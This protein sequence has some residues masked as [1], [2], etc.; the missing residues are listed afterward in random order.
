MKTVN[1]PTI[2]G[3]VCASIV[4]NMINLSFAL[5]NERTGQTGRQLCW[6]GSYSHPGYKPVLDEC[7]NLEDAEVLHDNFLYKEW[8]EETF[9][10]GNYIYEGYKDISF[11]I[12]YAPEA[13]RTDNWQTPT[14][15]IRLEQGD[16]EDA[17]FLFFSHLPP[18]QKNAEIVWGWVFDRQLGVARAHVWY[19]L[20][21][22]EGKEYIVEGFSNDWN[23]IIPMEIA[24]KT[25][26]R[27]PILK[28]T[29]LEAC[30]LLTSITKPDSGDTYRVLADLHRFTDLVK[31]GKNNNVISQNAVT[32]YH[33][34]AKHIKFKNMSREY[35]RSCQKSLESFMSFS[36][37]TR[38]N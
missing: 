24:K 36:P 9:T 25:E 15:T 31:F 12:K 8:C 1:I 6:S 26:I 11:N 18:T 21:D 7:P 2:A 3:M 20:K 34:D 5:D 37:G 23:G 33:L 30:R 16:C 27:T 22:R 17:V 4:L 13:A 32:S 35:K 28:I 29:H 38:N 19:Q 14:E 10:N